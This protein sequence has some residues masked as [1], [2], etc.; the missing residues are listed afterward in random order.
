MRNRAIEELPGFITLKTIL[1]ECISTTIEN[2]IY[3]Q[4]LNVNS[5][6]FTNN[7]KEQAV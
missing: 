2:T 6:Q 7:S 4:T 5:H 1:K 3:E